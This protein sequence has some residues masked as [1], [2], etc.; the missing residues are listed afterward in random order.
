MQ[1]RPYQGA[2]LGKCVALVVICKGVRLYKFFIEPMQPF[3]SL[4][5]WT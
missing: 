3:T 4:P 2:T 5:S 1:V